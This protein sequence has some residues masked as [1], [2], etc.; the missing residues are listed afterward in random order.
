MC[1]SAMLYEDYRRYIRSTGAEMDIYQFIEIFG[2]RGRGAKLTIPR[3]VERWFDEPLTDDERKVRELIS[4][5]RE[6]Q[7]TAWQQELFEQKKRLGDAERKLAVKET[8]AAAESKRIA[9]NKIDALVKKLGVLNDPKRRASDG[10]IFPMNY[11]PIVVNDN[12]RKVIRLARYHCRL[13]GKPAS[14][15]GQFPGLYNARRDNIDRYWRAAF[16]TSHAL[17]LVDSF[18]EN[19]DRGGK[20]AV[21]HFVPKPAGTML[22]ACVYSEWIDPKDGKRLLSFAAITDD[23]PPEVAAAGHDRMIVNLKP[24]NVDAWLSPQGRSDAELQ[25]ILSDRQAPYY[26]HEVL[27]A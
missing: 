15:D 13:A 24:E 22:I 16:G 8:K 20:N 6:K 19:V 7:A 1:F 17:M 10:R 18:Y 9:T 2:D 5:Y 11:A 25:A 26:E 21:L 3:M 14:V 27:A 12:G 23:P 4:A